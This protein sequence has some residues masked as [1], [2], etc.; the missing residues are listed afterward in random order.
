MRWET[1]DMVGST[2]ARRQVVA[3]RCPT[4]V[5][6]STLLSV[7]RRTGAALLAVA[8]ALPLSSL[9]ADPAVPR[10]FLLV[11]ALLWIIAVT[12]ARNGTVCLAAF[13]P[14]G[15]A[16]ARLFGRMPTVSV[17]ECVVFAFGSGR[18]LAAAWQDRPAKDRLSAPALVVAAAAVTSAIDELAV[19]GA[20]APARPFLADLWR[21]LMSG[22]WGPDSGEWIP[23]HLAFRWVGL[24]VAAVFVE[25]AVR[26]E[27]R[28]ATFLTW[29]WVS[30]AAAA[31]TFTV[32]RVVEVVARGEGSILES[33]TWLVTNHR[34]SALHPDPNAAGSSFGL[35]LV[36]A[37]IIAVRRRLIWMAIFVIPLLATGFLL[38][39]SRAAIGAAVVVLGACWLMSRWRDGRLAPVTLLIILIAILGSAVWMTASR[40]HVAP[41]AALGIRFQ[42]MQVAIRMAERFPWFGVG[43]GDYA[44]TSRRFIT[45]DLPTLS[46]F[47]PEGE[48]AHN[49]VLQVLVELGAP[50]A[51]A[52]IWL[53]VPPAAVYWARSRRSAQ[54]VEYEA[55]AAGLSV[56]LVSALFGHPL[57]IPEVAAMFFVALGLAASYLD[58]SRRGL[59]VSRAIAWA[60][61]AVYLLSL[62]FRL[63]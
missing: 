43:L 30:C 40:S 49:S 29:L 1:V 61:T 3:L 24:V 37:V 7:C 21:H 10:A 50:A 58:V 25:R 55:L 5:S 32:Q 8:L 15:L 53:L 45:A 4:S 59:D 13:V 51:A 39:Q 11:V 17:I 41:S 19:V 47:A 12:S 6:R 46:N 27:P 36:A 63:P 42:M 54:P 57:L 18:A 22:Y 20:V 60:L 9:A 26:S 44:R 14:L 28:G 31:T 38:A 2:A 33:L 48:N 35:L 52:F 56:F 62:P 23:L 34:L 16:V